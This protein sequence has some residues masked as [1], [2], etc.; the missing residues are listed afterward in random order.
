MKICHFIAS[1]LFGGAEKVVIDLCNE[2]SKEHKVFLI[3]FDK[4]ENLKNISPNV[5]VYSIKE[6]KRYNFIAYNKLAKLIITIDP[7]IINTHGAKSTKIIYNIRKKLSSIFI[8]TKHNARTGR[9]FNKI[10]NVIAVSQ[11]AK[12]SILHNNVKV[13]Y[14]GITPIK[15][16]SKMDNIDKVFTLVAIGRLDPIK[17]FDKLIQECSKLNFS[18][19]LYIIGEGKE[20]KNLQKLIENL[21]LESKI[22]LLGFQENIPQYMANADC[23]VISSHSEGFS[24]VMVE[25]FYYANCMISTKVS[26]AIEV[27]PDKLLVEQDDLSNKIEEIHKNLLEYQSYYTKL[28]EKIYKQ[29]LL[30]NTTDQYID[31]YK[32]LSREQ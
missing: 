7:D 6:F 24:L 18:F 2:M 19:I 11:E 20:K 32:T 29:F 28:K 3:T 1:S 5:I 14:N 26:G 25:A 15:I 9:I 22:K 10:D 16:H 17:G 13:I 31:Y 30:S 4:K 23:V 21:N 12:E 27:L 8:G